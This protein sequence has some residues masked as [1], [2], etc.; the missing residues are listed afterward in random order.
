[1]AT[2]NFDDYLLESLKNPKEASAYLQAALMEGD[3]DTLL[4]ALRTLAHAKGGL[5]L[6]AQKTGIHRV[7]LYKMLGKG[8]NPSFKNIMTVLQ[9]LGVEVDFS[10][11]RG[12]GQPPACQKKYAKGQITKGQRLKKQV[13]KR[14]AV[15]R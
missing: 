5:A 10:V 13:G 1:M 8:G 15:A 2:L 9:A 6:L 4:I 12:L 11:R 14:L 3:S 7:H